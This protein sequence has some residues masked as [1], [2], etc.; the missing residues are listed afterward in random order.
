VER[1]SC[2]DGVG[3]DRKRECVGGMIEK[4]SGGSVAAVRFSPVQG[5]F[6]SNPEPDHRSGS[7]KSP[8]PNLNLPERFF[9]SGPGFGEVLNPN[10]TE[11][12]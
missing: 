5:P 9:R 8:N 7:G 11:R 2:G 1:R 4:Q 12:T 10:R 6:S 3:V